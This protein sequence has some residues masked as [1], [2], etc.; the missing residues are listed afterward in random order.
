MALGGE[1]S[2]VIERPM[3]G[4]LGNA[5]MWK[6]VVLVLVIALPGCGGITFEN[7]D[8]VEGSYT[9]RSIAGRALPALMSS[10]PEQLTV[11]SGELTL[12]GDG[13]WSEVLSYST[14]ENGQGVL[15]TSIGTG[16]WT[17]RSRNVELIRADGAVISGV[18]SSFSGPKLE[19]MRNISGTQTLAVYAR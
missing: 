1:A 4:H 8:Q 17:L 11:T 5:S 7:D 9:L 3:P 12:E 6:R 2:E 13:D 15:K 14:V 16:R 10:G 18:F 19:L